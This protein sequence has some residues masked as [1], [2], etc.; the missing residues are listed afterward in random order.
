M[1][2]KQKKPDIL[3]RHFTSYAEELVQFY[4][5][6]KTGEFDEKQ[7]GK[8]IETTRSLQAYFAERVRREEEKF[9]KASAF[10][11][12]NRDLLEEYGGILAGVKEN[13]TVSLEDKPKLHYI[14]KNL[15]YNY[16]LYRMPGAVVE[17]LEKILQ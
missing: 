3:K 2:R 4:H 12:A 1:V 5:S 13:K 10:S 9:F 8:H 11:R 15:V 17:N 6:T 14:Y 16:K 7:I